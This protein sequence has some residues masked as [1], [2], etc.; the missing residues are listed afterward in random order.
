MDV[1]IESKLNTY[2]PHV[3]HALGQVR[4]LILHIAK[5]ESLG[6]VSE[7]LKWQQLSYSCPSGS[8]IRI[9]WNADSPQ[10]IS[11]FCHCQT[12]LIASFKEVYPNAFRYLGNREMVLAINQI[13]A[14]PELTHCISVAL[15]YH[16]VKDK[17]LLGL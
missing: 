16:Q 10:T 2:P 9:D 15:K 7:S 3:K 5:S 1:S 14:N 11:I 12:K 4:E 6:P 8:P 13:S 17:P